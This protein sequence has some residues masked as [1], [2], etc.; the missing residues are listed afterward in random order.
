MVKAKSQPRT[1]RN[2]ADPSA[3]QHAVHDLCSVTNAFCEE[4]QGAPSPD[5]SATQTFTYTNRAVGTLATGASGEAYIVLRASAF[6]NNY[7]TES[8]AGAWSARS[9]YNTSVGSPPAFIDQARVVSAGIR[10]WNLASMTSTQATLIV[11]PIPEDGTFL[12]GIGHTLTEIVNSPGVTISSNLKPGAF[13]LGPLSNQVY[14]YEE[15][16]SATA[17]PVDNGWS[18]CIVVLS[19]AASTTY[20]GYEIV[21]N[22]EG[23]VSTTASFIGGRMRDAN[24]SIAD[25]FRN[26]RLWAGYAA[27]AA[28]EIDRLT[29]GK[30][31]RFLLAAGTK[32]LRNFVPGG[33]A[34]EAGARLMLTNG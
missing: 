15:T 12:N 28:S 20:I 2:Q 25:Y 32:V 27:G 22:Y 1:E 7:I 14:Q 5:G 16:D 4:A 29:Q 17:T 18:S 26:A 8:P 21:I 34:I 9:S 13:L 23:V 3:V 30:A 33:R 31:R 19:G 24:P 11:A 10:W 6:A